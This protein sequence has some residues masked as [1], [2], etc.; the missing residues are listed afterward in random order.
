MG[1]CSRM[2]DFLCENR[3]RETA[4]NCRL[5]TANGRGQMGEEHDPSAPQPVAS[6]QS[7]AACRLPPAACRLLLLVFVRPLHPDERLRIDHV[8]RSQV[9]LISQDPRG[10]VEQA[11]VR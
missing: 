7:P 2:Y 6:R 9:A 11:R 4:E 10:E 1:M 3:R 5:Q 8:P